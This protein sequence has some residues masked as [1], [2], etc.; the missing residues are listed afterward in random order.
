MFLLILEFK[1]KDLWSRKILEL[2]TFSMDLLTQVIHL[3]S[4]EKVILIN[5]YISEMAP[6]FVIAN[7]GF[8]VWLGNSR[9][10]KHSH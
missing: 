2:S 1:P 4:I 5:L 8:D 10:N 7:E 3:L 9:G 6:A